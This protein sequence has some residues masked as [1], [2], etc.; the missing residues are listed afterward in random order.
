MAT[1]AVAT[2]ELHPWV[3]R[4]WEVIRYVVVVMMVK[5]FAKSWK[6]YGKMWEADKPEVQS[7]EQVNFHGV[8]IAAV[9]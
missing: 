4:F 3:P 2:W 8:A 7:P 6:E 5:I 9:W 1:A